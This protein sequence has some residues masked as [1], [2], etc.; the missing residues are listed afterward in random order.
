LK[1]LLFADLYFPEGVSNVLV[2]VL[3]PLY[4]I[5]L[6][7]PLEI[8]TIVVG[9]GWIPWII[10]FLWSGVIDKYTQ[11]GRKIYVII[12]GFIAVI[13]LFILFFIDPMTLLIPFIII[14]F[15]S[16]I[17]QTLLDS[18]ADAWGI[19][20]ST[21]ENRGKINGAMNIG[22][23]LGSGIGIII[24]SFFAES[25]GYNYMF[26]IAGFII[27]INIILPT[28]ISEATKIIKEQK[29][30]KILWKEF[31]KKYVKLLLFYIPFA[32]CGAG[33]YA[34][35]LPIFANIV[36]GLSTI[37][38]GYIS[39]IAIIF[40][41][42]GSILG[43]IISDRF[44]RKKAI[45]IM[46]ILSNIFVISIIFTNTLDVLI[47][48]FFIISFFGGGANTAVFTFYM[49]A[50][51][52]KIGGTQFSLYNG[53]ANLGYICTGTITGTLIVLIGYNNVFLISGLFVIP[54]VLILRFINI[55]N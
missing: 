15:C 36:L 38:I 25:F 31:Q 52:P 50:T 4:F 37:Q 24:L 26:L 14:L 1:Y 12:G 32:A 8:I 19:D 22:M 47:I 16:Q 30:K 9:L 35:A 7:F 20:V 29:V 55:K 33:L 40:T 43:G 11:R 39:G 17:G 23:V 10:K 6:G 42:S 49:D 54:T 3:I 13:C 27:L 2:P 48:L 51:N 21:N 46:I 18:A 5:S 28:I 53:L 41:I 34:F 45:Y 44:G